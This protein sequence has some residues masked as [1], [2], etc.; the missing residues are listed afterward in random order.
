MHNEKYHS[1][2]E[3][4]NARF[5]PNN[6]SGRK[7]IAWVAWDEVCKPKELGGLEVKDLLHFNHALPGKWRRSRLHDKDVFWV[8]VINSKYG[9]EWPCQKNTTASRWWKDLEKVGSLDE[10]NGGWFVDN[11]WKEI[12][13]GL[14]SYFW[15][16]IWIGNQSL[17]MVFPRLFRLASNQLSCVADNGSWSN[18]LIRTRLTTKD[19]LFKEMLL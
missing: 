13:N 14:H 10:V 4:I 19:E 16:D 18:D 5:I 1:S 15:H 17:K 9:T 11:V 2:K 8:K 7:C 3:A 6:K 12:G